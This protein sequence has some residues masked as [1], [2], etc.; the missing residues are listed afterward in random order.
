MARVDPMRPMARTPDLRIMC[1][2]CSIEIN[3]VTSLWQWAWCEDF[4]HWDGKEQ[5]EP[6]RKA[7][8]G[9]R[10]ASFAPLLLWRQAR[11]SVHPGLPLDRPLLPPGPCLLPA[12]A[13]FSPPL[14][15][16]FHPL[17][18]P[19]AHHSPNSSLWNITAVRRNC[20]R[21]WLL[22]RNKWCQVYVSKGECIKID[23]HMY[24]V[25]WP[26]C[27]SHWH[28]FWYLVMK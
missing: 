10:A 17:V 20:L 26:W 4:N 6:E 16:T 8:T 5:C 1:N 12:P 3:Q 13:G 11:C 27:Q 25:C 19:P 18:P 2:Y 15:P 22:I 24:L 7:E 14:L 28:Y 9:R 23:F 21:G